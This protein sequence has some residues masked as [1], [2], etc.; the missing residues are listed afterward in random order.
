MLDKISFQITCSMHDM[1]NIQ[2]AARP[3]FVGI[4][5]KDH[6]AAKG[7]AAV[8]TPNFRPRTAYPAGQFC[9]LFAIIH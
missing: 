1:N 8:I 6:I 2:M 9:Y 5:Q 4:T 3:V 7:D